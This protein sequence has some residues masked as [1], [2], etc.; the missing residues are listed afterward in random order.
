MTEEFGGWS[1][2]LIHDLIRLQGY[3]IFEEIEKE[4]NLTEENK[5]NFWLAYEH[6]KK[7]EYWK[8]KEYD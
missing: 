6:Y 1:M 2:E 4:P 8:T 3:D 5:K 7:I